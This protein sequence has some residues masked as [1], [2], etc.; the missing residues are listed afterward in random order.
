MKTTQTDPLLRE[1]LDALEE[2]GVSRTGFGYLAAGDPTLVTKM[3]RGRRILKP[4]LRNRIKDTIVRVG[5]RAKAKAA[6]K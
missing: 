2:T 6:L 4:D 1:I 3:E 5:A